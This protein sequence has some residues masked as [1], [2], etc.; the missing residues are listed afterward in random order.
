[1]QFALHVPW[2]ALLVI[3]I[4][5]GIVAWA[6]YAGRIVSL[7]RRRQ[8]AL[9]ALRAATLVLLVACLLRPV[10]V[11]PPDSTRGPAV[12]VLVDVS[13][14]M[15]L[16][17]AGGR[18]RI[19]A[20]RDLVE[21][22][23][24]PALTGEFVPEIWTF[25][26][27]LER[28]N[29]TL[30]AD[31]S[32]SDLRGALRGVR[33]RYR[34]R[35]VA[36]F[37]VVSDGGDTSS[38]DAATDPGADTVPV[39]TIG[40]GSTHTPA[41]LEVVAVSA[42]EMTMADSA[43]DISVAAVNRG[44]SEPFDLRLLENGRP[45]DIRRVATAP[46]GGPVRTVFTVSPPR[47]VPAVYTVEIPTAST[48]AVLEN[49][50]RAVIVEPT[51]RRRR[52]LVIEGAPGFEHSFLKRALAL[53]AG[54]ELDSVV[55]KGRDARGGATYFVQAAEA[56]AP[57]LA[58]GFPQEREALYEYDALVIANMEGDALSRAQLQMVADFVD[59]RG[60]GLLMLG[61]KSFVQQGFAGTPLE[62]L[63][64]LRLTDRGGGVVRAAARPDAR[65]AVSLTADG[66]AHPVMQL[67][68]DGADPSDRW[69]ALPA[70]SNASPLGM[71]R[72]GAQALAVVRTPDGSRPLVAVQQYGKGRSMVFT[73][74][75]SWRWRM[76]MPSDDRS[77]ERFWRQAVRWVAAGARDRVSI[78]TPGIIA[79]GD[80]A[81]VSVDARNATFAAV[82]DAKVTLTVTE[83]DGTERDVSAPL[84]DP[85]SGRYAADVRF[86]A[87]GIYRLS[88]AAQNGT[89]ALT[90]ERWV[91]VGGADLEM[92]NP[93][94]NEQVL[95]RI[96][97]ASGGRY[98]PA[99]SVARLPPLLA[100]MQS[101]PAAPRLQELWHTPWLFAALT[102]LLAAEWTL[103]R[104]W[105]L[106]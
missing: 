99:D 93:R 69:A 26:D 98:L 38:G 89:A 92:A 10:R 103:R 79:P 45:V 65:Y 85:Q 20:A 44:G 50:R 73:G 78:T 66:A 5:I 56:R 22:T 75:A 105:G 34:D 21:R 77:Y 8:A 6:S 43:V 40:V 55:R 96:A 60:G 33:E 4:G 42:G 94:L 1:M 47:D 57:R 90:G 95:Q 84:A 28:M 63:V 67:A 86:D 87:P 2:W 80:A 11:M 41:D 15:R 74:E 100:A 83:P 61:A 27:S 31:A 29:G 23:L 54:L 13:R 48:E 14:S 59:V 52:I 25:G 36:A 16:A 101:A 53:D 58:A 32:A 24:R 18:P 3:A 70:L 30:A 37:V 91:L 62:D 7:P 35:P 102:V 68:P 46:D 104:R 12:P 49:N 64:P 17:D 81:A 71:L 82:N 72:P 9:T 39:Y 97:E 76:R 106:R 51:G 88:A 19:D